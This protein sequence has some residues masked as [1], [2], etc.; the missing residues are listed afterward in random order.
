MK[1]ESDT[2]PVN[3]QWETKQCQGDKPAPD[4][5]IMSDDVI[6]MHPGIN[7]D[8]CGVKPIEGACYRRQAEND[9]EDFCQKCFDKLSDDEKATL[10]RVKGRMIQKD[11]AE[12]SPLDCPTSITL[13]P[14]KASKHFKS[15]LSFA[16]NAQ[17]CLKL[18]AEMGVFASA[19]LDVLSGGISA[20]ADRSVSQEHS[21]AHLLPSRSVLLC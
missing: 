17:S 8:G 14:G 7:C 5:Y 4:V 20:W 3:A 11:P 15:P 18:G 19:P 21:L 16:N 12:K 13:L 6:E 10:N 2:P 9:S 1:S